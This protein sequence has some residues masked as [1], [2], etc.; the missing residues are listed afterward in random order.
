M[1]HSHAQAQGPP[2]AALGSHPSLLTALHRPPGA[3]LPPREG[4]LEIMRGAMDNLDF[5]P[6]AEIAQGVGRLSKEDRSRFST[7]S[8][9]AVMDRL[10]EYT[11]DISCSGCVRTLRDALS[12]SGFWRSGGIAHALFTESAGEG[13]T[14][15]LHPL[16][17]ETG[18]EIL[19]RI[20]SIF[21]G[22]DFFSRRGQGKRQRCSLHT[23]HPRVEDDWVHVWS[24]LGPE[25]TGKISVLGVDELSDSLS[26]HLKQLYFCMDCR[27]NV[28]RALDLLVG[29]V[30]PED[31]E[32]D[33]EYSPD[34]FKPFSRIYDEDELYPPSGEEDD[35][36][37]DEDEALAAVA[38]AEAAARADARGHA[39][40]SRRRAGSRGRASE[41]GKR[42]LLQDAGSDAGNSADTL[43]HADFAYPYPAPEIYNVAVH[44]REPGSAPSLRR[45][46]DEDSEK[47]AGQ[48]ASHA[49]GRARGRG[50]Q[51]R[52]HGAR[53][54][55]EDHDHDGEEEEE[56]N[57]EDEDQTDSNY[58]SLAGAVAV[59]CDRAHVPKLL[60]DA[61]EADARDEAQRLAGVNSDR[62]APTLRDG[63]SEL[64]LCVG[65]LLLARIKEHRL[66]KLVRSQT[67]ELLVWLVLSCMRTNM[68]DLLGHRGNDALLALLE[69]EDREKEQAE[70]RKNKKKAKK[71]KKKENKKSRGA[72]NDD[73]GASD[74]EGAG[75]PKD[76]KEKT[77][78]TGTAAAVAPAPAA[79]TKPPSKAA[80]KPTAKPLL[81]P[82]P[83]QPAAPAPA[84]G[85]VLASAATGAAASSK[86]KSAASSS[87]TPSLNGRGWSE[88][89]EARL[90][91]Q[92]RVQLSE[93]NA[94][95]EGAE[96][97]DEEEEEDQDQDQ[98]QDDDDIVA[99]GRALHNSMF[100]GGLFAGGAASKAAQAPSSPPLPAAMPPSPLANGL[101]TVDD[102]SALTEEELRE[103]SAK[104]HAA[105]R[106]SSREQL[107][108]RLRAQFDSLVLARPST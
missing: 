23:A 58:S 72:A 92:F 90:M 44:E 100:G 11:Q 94:G 98:D 56:E 46:A 95:E 83:S 8:K 17:A 78:A 50:A 77:A 33:E 51:A 7:V 26:A 97:L 43:E 79:A 85:L 57:S 102:V 107:R 53:A 40:T 52:A 49:S 37:F 88:D 3:R 18:G 73:D 6:D 89:S 31:L 42:G 66:L 28:L 10:S 63:Q 96:E 9:K 5:K 59:A 55:E 87:A 61:L 25:E 48:R 93:S 69:E 20:F 108:K 36:D 75:N 27:G 4:I 62:H 15:S 47:S 13:G 60:R 74:D 64:L 84:R 14:V 67:D 71:Q 39:N 105:M 1:A 19:G 104:L 24:E 80:A 101:D 103:A 106:N 81:A 32:S 82:P 99:A 86:S 16:V 41:G 34:T 22:A 76:K 38:A 91:A 68:Q 12:G 29:C 45:V 65:K 54:G 2:V 21:N 30:D 35:V 70:A